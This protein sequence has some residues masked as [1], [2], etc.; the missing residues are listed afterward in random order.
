MM[1]LPTEIALITANLAL[2]YHRD[3]QLIKESFLPVFAEIKSC[4]HIVHYAL[5]HIIVNDS[6]ILD[7]KY[8]YMF[9]VEVVNDL[10][11]QGMSLPRCL[12]Q[13][14]DIANGLFQPKHQVQHTHIG[15]I[16]NLCNDCIADLMSEVV[17]SFRF[18]RVKTALDDL[19]HSAE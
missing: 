14:E 16:G 15:S 12:P 13:S 17:A 8:R 9:S 4:L 19:L 10:V 5:Q 3:L 11:V 1:A 18:D 2:G 7:E 6:A